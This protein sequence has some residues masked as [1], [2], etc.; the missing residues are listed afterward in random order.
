MSAMP[1]EPEQERPRGVPVATRD[2]EGRLKVSNKH[3]KTERPTD[4]DLRGNPAIGASKGATMAHATPD[5][6]EDALGEN[7]FEGDVGNDVNP[8]GG[9]DQNAARSGAHRGGS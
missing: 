1:P 6:V 9:V 4:S 8:Q 5:E 2:A 3:L 7:T